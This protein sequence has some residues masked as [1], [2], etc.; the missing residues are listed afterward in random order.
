MHWQPFRWE[1]WASLVC[2][3]LGVYG[4][5]VGLGRL[6]SGA[7]AG[8]G[9]LCLLFLGLFLDWYP[10]L[11]AVDVVMRKAPPPPFTSALELAAQI[12]AKHRRFVFQVPFPLARKKG[13]DPA[14]EV[15]AS[16]SDGL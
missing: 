5:C 6:G 4:L 8:L 1:V 7:R 3:A 13:A 16:G 2:L 12:K 11:L 14:G 15:A 10:S 9:T